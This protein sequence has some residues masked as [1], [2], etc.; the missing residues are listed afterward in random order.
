M[1][2]STITRALVGTISTTLCACTPIQLEA[3]ERATGT[4]FD[5]GQRSALVALP[6]APM[7]LDDEHVVTIS[8]E[9]ELR[10][11]GHCDQWRATMIDAGFTS[12]QFDAWISRVMYRESN[13]QPG[14]ISPTHDYGLMQIN[15]VVV[16]DMRQ[17]PWLWQPVLARLGHVPSYGELLDPEINALV[18]HSLWMIRGTAPWT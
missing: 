2:R 5:D 14:V 9:I 8:G 16:A 13:C 3:F 4:R 18:A 15:R 6:D 7:R 1:N 12:A 17:R 10:R 11:R